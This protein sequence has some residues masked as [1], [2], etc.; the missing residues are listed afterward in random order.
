MQIDHGPDADGLLANFHLLPLKLVV[1]EEVTIL[2]R[3]QFVGN[4]S[5]KMIV[6]FKLATHL[7]PNMMHTV[8]KLHENLRPIVTIT[9][10]IVLASF[11]KHVAK[12][13]PILFN[14]HLEAFESPIVR[15]QHK[16]SQ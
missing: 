1:V 3:V 4:E 15:V 12:G 11:S 10:R 5:Q 6:E 8:Q 14:E 16:L 9:A 7:M 2:A 13:D